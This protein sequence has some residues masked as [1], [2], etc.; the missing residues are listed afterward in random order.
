MTDAALMLIM[1]LI[2]IINASVLGFLGGVYFSWKRVVRSPKHA[3]TVILTAHEAYK[4]TGGELARKHCP[5]CGERIASVR[6][7]R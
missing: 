7:V 4:R 2:A 3:L 1:S 5:I 6:A